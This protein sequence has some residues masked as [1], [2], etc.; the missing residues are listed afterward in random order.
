MKI[1]HHNISCQG[2]EIKRLGY[3]PVKG[4]TGEMRISMTKSISRL[5]IFLVEDL[6]KI[7]LVNDIS[8]CGVVV[9]WRSG[10][11]VIATAQL[12]LTKPELR[13][14]SGSNPARS[15]SGF[16]DS[17][18]LWQ[19]SWLEIRLNTF[20]W[21]TIPQKQFIII[22]IIIIIIIIIINN[23]VSEMTKFA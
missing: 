14:C 6:Q 3:L 4:R 10:A 11:K 21:S 16:C 18:D 2:F 13:L 9:M 15:V 20:R 23:S 17:E 22:F 1:F 12:H 8:C 7:S 5:K 19:W